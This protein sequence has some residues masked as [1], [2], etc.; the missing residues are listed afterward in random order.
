MYSLVLNR[1]ILYLVLAVLMGAGL[2]FA[3]ILGVPAGML[4]K[5]GGSVAV[6]S[7]GW[8]FAPEAEITRNDQE[9]ER[10]L[11]FFIE[12]KLERERTRGR[13]IELLREI[14]NS[15]ATSEQARQKAQEDLMAISSKLSKETDLE[16]LLRARGY[17][18]ALV[19]IEDRGVTVI[20]LPPGNPAAKI[21]PEDIAK[22]CEVIS[23]GTGVGEQNIFV[24]P[25]T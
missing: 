24:I 2:L 16:H 15:P 14:I 23:W 6:E 20:V 18:D 3:G 4:K 19:C 21:T 17:Q 11:D 25:K 1:K 22:I 9:K 12:Y 13:Q 5:E 7:V 8:G 10:N